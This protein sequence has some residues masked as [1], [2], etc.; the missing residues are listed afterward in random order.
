MSS[1]KDYADAKD[2]AKW[3]N[4]FAG[5]TSKRKKTTPDNMSKE[6]PKDMQNV[7]KYG[8]WAKEEAKKAHTKRRSMFK[9]ARDYTPPDYGKRKK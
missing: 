8:K 2:A 6:P 4:E 7:K 3:A 1:I 9:K 5:L